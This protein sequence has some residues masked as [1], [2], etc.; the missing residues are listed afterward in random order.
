M[1]G[2]KLLCM[3]IYYNFNYCNANISLIVKRFNFLNNGAVWS[4]YLLNVII[5]IALF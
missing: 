4:L 5:R 3:N 2:G 1:Y